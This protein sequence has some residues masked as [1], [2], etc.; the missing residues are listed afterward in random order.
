MKKIVLS[1]AIIA[2]MSFF[3]ACSKDKVTCWEVKENLTGTTITYF[4]GTKADAQKQFP[5]IMGIG[6]TFTEVN[7]SQSDCN[8]F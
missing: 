7:K 5:T 4:W 2:T 6:Y 1:V 3:T 8:Y